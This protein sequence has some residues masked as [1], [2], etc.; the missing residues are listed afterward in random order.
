MPYHKVVL[1]DVID[2]L[3]LIEQAF[4]DVEGDQITMLHFLTTTPSHLDSQGK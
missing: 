3:T 2:K 4:E 1:W